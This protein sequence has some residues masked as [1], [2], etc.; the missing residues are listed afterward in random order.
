MAPTDS[1]TTHS[2]TVIERLTSRR[3]AWLALALGLLVSLA[4]IGGL[5]GVEAPPRA[6]AAPTTSESARV[7]DLSSRFPDADVQGVLLVATRDDGAPVD[8][9]DLAALTRLGSALPAAAGEAASPA[10][11]SADSRAAMVQLPITTSADN[12]QNA[13]TI[14]HLRELV[15][16]QTPPG[17]TVLVT[18]GPAFGADIAKAFDGANLTLLL[19]TIG[20]VA[21]LL[22]LTYRSPIL[23]L[24]PVVVVGLADQLAAV[25]T[26]VLGSALDLSFDAGIVS[27]L[28]FGAGT[29]YA[30]LLISRYREELRHEANHR[31]ALA[32]AWRATLPA[33]VASNATVVVAL[34]T[35][36]LAV[37]PGT[38]GL[39]V[40]SAA[41]LLVAL[42][43]VL[44]LLPAALAVVGRRIFWPFVPAV[45]GV[46][47]HHS[48]GWARV[49]TGVMRHPGRVVIAG[50]LAL[51]VMAAGLVGTT[52]GLAQTDQFRVASQSAT[53]LETL[54][55][56]FPAG[57]AQPLTIVAPADRVDHVVAAVREIPGVDSVRPV[58][59]TTGGST[60]LVRISVV[61]APNPG[62]SEA[63]D[64]V[65]SVRSVAHAV[66]GA[67]ALVGGQ[68]ATD[69]DA[70]A[71]NDRD[72]RLLVPLIL[73]VN[74]LVLMALTRS[75]VAPVV[76]L[77]VNI[78]SALATIGAGSWIGRHVLDWPGLDLQVPLLSFLFLVALGIDYTIFLVH[79][80]RSEAS[81]HGTRQ[82]MV[83][84]VG[85]TGAVITSAGIVLAA[86][87]AALGVLPL[88]ALGQLGLIVGLGVVIDTFL[89]RTVLV[90][91]LFG[92]LG[93]RVWWPGRGPLPTGPVAAAPSE[94]LARVA[95][96]ASPPCTV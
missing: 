38:R 72:L 7:A 1:V 33:I 52:V 61:T 12:G 23:W 67:D 95:E 66:P 11:P 77:G 57:A 82:G 63:R 71:G 93:E 91:G 26:K 94:D 85:G 2:S 74:A 84:A 78:L 42:V 15:A 49:A 54:A 36:A 86:V 8:Q 28:V 5:R 39:G 62:T 69:V 88:V 41:G 9:N 20:V 55:R 32:S 96:V 21:L 30:M 59:G 70:R 65:G 47:D 22:L 76:L 73:L 16:D 87:F 81:S 13:E 3:G 44:V 6:G 90:P 92:L 58:E 18:G 79:R 35:L 60:P 51:G 40:A 48:S 80:A 14:T 46:D 4:P 19:V 68:Q 31:T 83:R 50:I 89:V 25:L 37:T 10:I 75:L 45:D 17:V 56:H 53:G 34:A 27:V 43:G 24:V 64:L 29:N